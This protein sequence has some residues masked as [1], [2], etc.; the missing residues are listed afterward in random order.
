M[1]KVS[2][3]PFN[4]LLGVLLT[5]SQSYFEMRLLIPDWKSKLPCKMVLA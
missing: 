4:E 3:L 5:V 2:D 1:E